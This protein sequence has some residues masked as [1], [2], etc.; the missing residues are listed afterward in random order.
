MENKDLKIQNNKIYHIDCFDGF[1]EL[2]DNSVS[3][4]FTSPPYNRK[5]N[6]KYMF[7]NDDIDDY[8][9]DKS[10]KS[11]TTYT[12]NIISTSVN[13]KMPKSHK[14]VMKQEV[15]DWFIDKFTKEFDLILDPF[16]GLG[17]YCN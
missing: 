12:K 4:V 6:D 13:S 10:L 7:H 16:M 14:A 17:T 8:Y 1:K 5:R 11:N 3:H 15:S 9:G 2:K